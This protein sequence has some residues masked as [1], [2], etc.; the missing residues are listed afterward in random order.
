MTLGGD[1]PVHGEVYGI[2]PALETVLDA[3]EGLGGDHPTD[4]YR[5][6]E[7]VVTVEGQALSCLVYEIHPRYALGARRIEHRDWLRA[8][9]A[10]SV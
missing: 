4:E 2:A 9:G 6:R 5:R 1:R 8:V 3:I 10:T 7:I